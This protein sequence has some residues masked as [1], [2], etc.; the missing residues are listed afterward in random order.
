[1]EENGKTNWGCLILVAIFILANLFFL[2][3]D[4]NGNVAG[5]GAFILGIA[6]IA[7]IWYVIK[8]FSIDDSGSS[9]SKISKTGCIISVVIIV[10]G[11]LALRPILGDQDVVYAVGAIAAIA[12]AIALGVYLYNQGKD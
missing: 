4:D 9:N 12:L 2:F 8:R 5:F 3:N 10:V 6:V 11:L 1:M 7:G